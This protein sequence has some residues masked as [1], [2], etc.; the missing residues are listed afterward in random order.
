MTTGTRCSPIAF[1]KIEG[2]GVF[3]Q[4]PNGSESVRRHGQLHE[5]ARS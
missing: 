3:Y 4:Q 5:S 1:Q 2:E